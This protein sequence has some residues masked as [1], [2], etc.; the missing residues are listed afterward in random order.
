M[1][2]LKTR[3]IPCPNCSQLIS[4]DIRYCSHCQADLAIAAVIAERA[5]ATTPLFPERNHSRP[6]MLVPRLGEQLVK[7]GI[8]ERVDLQRA[9]EKQKQLAFQGKQILI[10]QIL[11]EMGLVKRE[12]LDHVVTQHIIQLQSALAANNQQLESQVQQ[13]TAQLQ[14][15]LVK[16]TELNQLKLNFISNVSHE[17]RMPMQFLVGYLDLLDNGTLGDLTSEQVKAVDSMQGASNQ[18]KTLIEDL[19]QF[20]SA[21]NGEIPLDMAPISLELPVNTA[22]N[23]SEP[24]ARTRNIVLNSLRSSQ[25]PKVVADNKKITWVVEQFLDNAIKFT[26]PGGNV[27]IETTPHRGDVIVQVTDTGIG[28]PANRIDEIF[29]PFHQ[30]DSSATRH[31]GGTGLG[32][33]LARSIV[34]AHGSS[35][36]VD[37]TVGRGSCFSFSLPAIN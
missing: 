10:G 22:V 35:I 27:K 6:E 21:A 37:S 19:L 7:K 5:L 13:R 12:E 33:A 4:P 8:L 23:Q 3:V 36:Q 11:I 18:L 30:L 26:P 15:A 14:N 34:K 2:N 32:L 25:I 20:A 16:L 1:L 9:L 29:E 31:Y 24:K 28:I 17:L